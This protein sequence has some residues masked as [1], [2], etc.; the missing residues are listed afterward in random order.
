MRKEI[1]S[2]VT[3][4]QQFIYLVNRQKNSD[5]YVNLRTSYS[6]RIENS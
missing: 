4:T 1:E 2:N 6:Y 5:R 3:N